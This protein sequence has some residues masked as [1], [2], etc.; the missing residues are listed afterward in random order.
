MLSAFR[1]LNRFWQNMLSIYFVV[2]F[3]YTFIYVIVYKNADCQDIP[4]T[5]PYKI[6]K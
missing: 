5:I 6:S 4:C 3:G 2:S 1:L